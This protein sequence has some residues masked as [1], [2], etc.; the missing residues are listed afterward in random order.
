MYRIHGRNVQVD[1]L[2]YKLFC[3]IGKISWW[4]P[5]LKDRL[6]PR[7]DAS[8]VRTPPSIRRALVH[9]G[10]NPPVYLMDIYRLSR[11]VSTAEKID[12]T[13]DGHVGRP[14]QLTRPSC[15]QIDT[16]RLVIWSDSLTIKYSGQGVDSSIKFCDHHCGSCQIGTSRCLNKEIETGWGFV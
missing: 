12:W 9:W 13:W 8:H 7:G 1:R 2:I 11:A 4:P 15:I 5:S 3:G 14:G 6:I 10:Y 16:E